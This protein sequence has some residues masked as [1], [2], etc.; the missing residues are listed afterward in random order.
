MA[1][2]TVAEFLIWVAT[3]GGQLLLPL[4]PHKGLGYMACATDTTYGANFLAA[5]ELFFDEND[6]SESDIEDFKVEFVSTDTANVC[7]DPN[8]VQPGGGD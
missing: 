2:R 7:A 6:M 1:K 8:W 3:K 5:M 4:W